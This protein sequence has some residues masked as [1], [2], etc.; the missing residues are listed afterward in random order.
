[1]ENI[2]TSVILTRGAYFEGRLSF[3]G[4]ARLSGRFKGEIISEGVLIIDL[5]AKVEGYI[6]VGELIVK[7]WVKGEAVA[8]QKI[9]LLSGSEFY[10]AVSSPQLHIEE[11]AHF[12]GASVKNAVL[13][14]KQKLK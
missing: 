10:G 7:G 8:H 13:L 3:E 14:E 1:M 4:M 6:S 11:G 12:E 5:G 9:S 2:N